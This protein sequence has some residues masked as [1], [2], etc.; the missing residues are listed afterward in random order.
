MREPV[1]SQAE[2][3]TRPANQNQGGYDLKPGSPQLSGRTS[4]SQSCPCYVDHSQPVP[5]ELLTNGGYP[6]FS[7][8][9]TV[10]LLLK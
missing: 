10:R 5:Y 4:A 2:V 1:P 9:E 8:R 6:R 7:E 3:S